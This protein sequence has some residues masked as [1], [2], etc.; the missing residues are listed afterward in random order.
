[1]IPS[2]ANDKERRPEQD[3]GRLSL[4]LSTVTRFFHMGQADVITISQVFHFDHNKAT[5][6]PITCTSQAALKSNST[7]DC[8]LKQA[9]QQI[10]RCQE[11]PESN[12]RSEIGEERDH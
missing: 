3:P 5:I 9:E 12:L 6:I 2:P 10:H 1:M 4:E 8:A 7:D 11:N